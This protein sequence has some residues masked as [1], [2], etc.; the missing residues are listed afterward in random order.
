MQL[1]CEDREI[2]RVVLVDL[3][4]CNLLLISLG[5]K[6]HVDLYGPLQSGDDGL[7]FQDLVYQGNFK[8][9]DPVPDGIF[10]DKIMRSARRARCS[11]KS[12]RKTCFATSSRSTS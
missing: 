2:G 6:N 4:R 9:M 3:I 11:R 12:A 5:G 8:G 10:G 1:H 7:R